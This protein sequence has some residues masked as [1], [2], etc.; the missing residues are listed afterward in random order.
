MT[1]YLNTNLEYPA[2]E[3]LPFGQ[4]DLF[5]WDVISEEELMQRG[6]VK[7]DPPE[8]N[9]KFQ[10]ATY[11]FEKRDNGTIEV[12]YKIESKPCT[13][14][15]VSYLKGIVANRRWLEETG[16]IN[17]KIVPFTIPTTVEAI[18]KIDSL[19]NAYYDEYLKEKSKIDFNIGENTASLSLKDLEDIKQAIVDH[20]Q[21]CHSKQAELYNK[22][23]EMA[24]KTETLAIDVYNYILKEIN[25]PWTSFSAYREIE[26]VNTVAFDS[27]IDNGYEEE[28]EA[29]PLVEFPEG[30]D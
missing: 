4:D 3:S 25:D 9:S 26:K 30:I 29:A 1:M 19:L 14:S 27:T 17:V 13:E 2:P 28:V 18:A 8:Y 23:E 21:A 24:T 11:T 6:W 5:D 12:I 16:G 20:T 7:F 15:I 22:I 10:Y